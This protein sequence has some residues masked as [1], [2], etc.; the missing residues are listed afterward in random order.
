M[1]FFYLILFLCGFSKVYSQENINSLVDNYNKFFIKNVDLVNSV[2][3]KNNSLSNEN[4][5]WNEFVNDNFSMNNNFSYEV[6]DE[7]S[8]KDIG[9][10]WVSDATYNFSPGISDS[11]DL[12][13]RSKVSTGI[14]WGILGEG[15]I[16]KNQY[17]KKIFNKK[18]KID[19]LE[20]LKVIDKL[21][22]DKKNSIIELIFDNS[23]LKLLKSYKELLEAEVLYT[24]KAFN[25]G[26]N[27]YSEKL[28]TDQKLEEI[29]N[30]IDFND[31]Y[32]ENVPNILEKYYD[33]P[34][35]IDDLPDVSSIN[36]NQL[37]DDQQQA[38]NLK[39]EIEIENL[40]ISNSPSLK[41]K[42]RYNYYDSPNQSGRSFASISASFSVPIGSKK[43][44]EKISY[45]NF[46]DE[47]KLDL[48]KIRFKNNLI[49]EHKEFYRLLNVLKNKENEVLYINSLLKNELY[50]YKEYNKN[51]SPSKYI[52]YTNDLIK[53]EFDLIDIKQLLFEKYVFFH[54]LT[55][56]NYK[57][58]NLKINEST[59]LWSDFFAN[60]SNDV[61]IDLLLR[62]NIN[63]VFI[64]PGNNI[65]KLK[66][67]FE[68]AKINNIKLSRLIGE[69]S[70][71]K[72][73][74][75]WPL[76]IKKLEAS[77]EL[78][79]SA[80]HLDI[81]P[82]T[83]EDYK[84]NKDQYINIFS[85]ILIKCKE[86][87]DI[88]NIEL[89]VSIPMHLPIENALILKANNIKSYIM[90]Y[91]DTDQNKLFDRTKNLR[92]VLIDNYT[93]V[94]R[95]NDFNSKEHLKLTKEHLNE[96][97]IKSVGYYDLSMLKEL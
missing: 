93:W 2:L 62:N 23:R 12:F 48:E 37:F 79:F 52:K 16:S 36:I 33:I 75:S 8:L 59:Y 34:Y 11:E 94:I 81:E 22:L 73:Q 57:D 85:N 80:L 1:K 17:S 49:K 19:S 45:E 91:G 3:Q 53:T 70:Y 82:H 86:W 13:F 10:K 64:S 18:I 29:I 68:L 43:F 71:A 42:L 95:V 96:L 44:N 5:L 4:Y 87:S 20:L 31:K 72:D 88:N 92:D 67:L 83:F 51:F 41:A 54:S 9:L 97:G 50:I 14:D 74:E 90:A 84:E 46:L 30:L 63:E 61:I 89:S 6:N 76:L 78:G 35:Q 27:S 28:N 58:L 56:F 26:F 32:F 7:N 77:K 47:K 60:T 15:S 24:N 66:E 65:D 40:K 39:K 38:I 69:N 55:K 25:L 21:E